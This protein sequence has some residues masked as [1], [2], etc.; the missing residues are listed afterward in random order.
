MRLSR[1]IFAL[2]L[3]A[4]GLPALAASNFADAPHLH[5]QL[6]TPEDQLYPGGNNI[7]GLYF[8]LEPGWHIYWKNAGDSGEPPHIHWT[9]PEG[10]TAGAMQF[11]APQAAAARSVDGLRL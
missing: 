3:L 6:V 2:F 8:K 4:A 11:P 5:L 9:L 10:V 1:L 7:V